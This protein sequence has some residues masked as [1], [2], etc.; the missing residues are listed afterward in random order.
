M[1][2]CAG[3]PANHI[4]LSSGRGPVVILPPNPSGEEM[5]PVLTGLENLLLSP[6]D[7]LRRSRIG[8]L[9]NPASVD[10]RLNHAVE[11]IRMVLPP[12]PVLI[13][14]PQHG[15]HAEKQDNMIESGDTRDPLFRVP[16]HSLYGRR[17]VP[18][19]SSMENIDVLL[20]DLQDVGCRVYT[21]IYTL[22]YCMETAAALGKKVVVLDRPNPIGGRVIEGNRLS[23]DCASFVGRYPIPMR[24]GL[25]IAEAALLFNTRFGIGCDL[26]VI[27][28]E[29]WHRDMYFSDTG[30]FWVPP[31][32]NLPSPEAALVY[33]GQVLWEGT[34]ISEGR[35]TTRPFEIFGAPFLDPYAI[36]DRLT[37]GGIPGVILRPLAF[38]PTWNK[39]QGRLCKGFQMHVTDRSRIRPY[40]AALKLI[41]VVMDL[42]P[43]RFEWKPPPYEYEFERM[44]I[45]LILGD[46]RIRRKLE[47]THDVDGLST[48]WND[49]LETFRAMRARFLLYPEQPR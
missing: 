48:L 20:V 45:D 12:N 36:L 33:P 40:T 15:F 2:F 44:P 7:W 41:R 49:D 16:V 35:G 6:P 27:P 34:N 28:M 22:S 18:E 31:S 32:P 30:L 42:Y 43:D 17:R 1:P 25:T 9:C 3:L 11:M 47:Q 29:G 37:K 39:W 10:H 8:L 46:Q 24:H 38:E 5:Q 4:F 14:S 21:F 23:P 26:T 13:Y 19:K